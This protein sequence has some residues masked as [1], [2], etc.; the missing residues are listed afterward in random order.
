MPLRRYRLKILVGVI[1]AI[2]WATILA[3]PHVSGRAT[4]IDV[5]EA[6]LLDL[7]FS[8]WGPQAASGDVVI[9]AIDDATL[10]ADTP[11][12][13]DGRLRIAN[14][15]ASIGA[16]GARALAVDQRE[17]LRA[18]SLLRFPAIQ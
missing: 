12:S 13:G 2:A 14:L 7:R 5:F 6:A 18:G 17:V 10:S 1:G 11:V 9:V 16:A 4:P 15:I 8:I 3:L